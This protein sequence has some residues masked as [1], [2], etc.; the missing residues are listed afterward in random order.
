MGEA[1]QKTQREGSAILLPSDDLLPEALGTAL[2]ECQGFQGEHTEGENTE[3]TE[4]PRRA[5]VRHGG[6]AHAPHGPTGFIA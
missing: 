5:Q 3:G 1:Y 4:T 6:L 2:E